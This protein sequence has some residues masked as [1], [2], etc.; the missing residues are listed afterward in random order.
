MKFVDDDDDDEKTSQV[1]LNT[2]CS[3]SMQQKTSNTG[4]YWAA[5]V[6]LADNHECYGKAPNTMCCWVETGIDIMEFSENRI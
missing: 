5:V 3:L 1:V 4:Q 6:D 2:D